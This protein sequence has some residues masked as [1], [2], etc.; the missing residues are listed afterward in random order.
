LPA[1]DSAVPSIRAVERVCD[2][3]DRLRDAA[4]GMSLTEIADVTKLPKSTIHRYLAALAARGYV[5]RDQQTNMVR[6][7]LAFRPKRAQSIERFLRF[8]ESELVPFR[9]E[10]GETIN[11][12]L[13]DGG[14][15]IHAVVVESRQIVR[16]AARVGERAPLHCTAIG[17]VIA[18][19]LPTDQVRAILL[20]E[21]MPSITSRTI[22]AVDDYLRDVERA[23]ERGYAFDDSEGQEDGRCVAVAL[24]GLDVPAGLSL[25]APA[26]RLPRH[27]VADVGAQLHYWEKQ[28]ILRYAQDA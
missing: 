9:D 23:H 28:L 16:L 25:S 20:R 7:G 26:R 27:R 22:T 1:D 11:I 3:F 15:Y 2:I 24:T 12:G 14:Q 10:T 18:G 13:L 8:A 4:E 21:G 17:K 6:P 5:E 19:Q